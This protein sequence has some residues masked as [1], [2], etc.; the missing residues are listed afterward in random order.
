MTMLRRAFTLL[1]LL[2]VVAIMGVLGTISIGGYFAITAGMAERGAIEAIRGILKVANQRAMI[3]DC[4]VYICLYNEVLSPDE[5][6]KAS[7]V[8]GL[9][10]VVKGAGR[11]TAV[12]N[13]DTWYDEF[14]DMDQYFN[15]LRKNGEPLKTEDDFEKAA[16]QFRLFKINDMSGDFVTVHNGKRLN[17]GQG[18][19]EPDYEDIISPESATPGQERPR[20]TPIMAYGYKRVSGSAKFVVG[21]EYG[22][23][24][25]SIRLPPG[26]TFASGK[27]SYSVSDAGK[28]I[29]VK[30]ERIPPSGKTN[31]KLPLFKRSPDGRTY[32][33]VNYNLEEG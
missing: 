33:A 25:A 24:F 31:L 20:P 26:F 14:A 7:K 9:A 4:P 21:E 10:I 5:D 6:D 28:L 29:S 27:S 11:V 2:T 19:D 18:W 1:E 12:E 15:A 8:S 32:T 3:D 30:V 17:N 23:E 16:T 22:K 13:N